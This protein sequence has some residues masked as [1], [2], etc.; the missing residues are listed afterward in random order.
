MLQLISLG[1]DPFVHLLEHG[2]NVWN[3]GCSPEAN[4]ENTAEKGRHKN[5]SNVWIL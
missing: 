4:S 2:N 5:Q 1:H 3:T